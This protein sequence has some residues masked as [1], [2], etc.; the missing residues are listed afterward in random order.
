M[1]ENIFRLIEIVVICIVF[2]IL[3]DM[4]RIGEFSMLKSISYGA[5]LLGLRLI[6]WR[7]SVRFNK[8]NKL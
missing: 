1:I 5:F 2:Y 6:L 8:R 7:D 4:Y 3:Y